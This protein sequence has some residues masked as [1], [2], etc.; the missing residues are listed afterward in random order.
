MISK[1]IHQIWFQGEDKIPEKLNNY[2]NECKKI[3]K[4]YQYYIWDDDMI[5]RL[6][7]DN[8]PDYYKTY[9]AFPLMIQKIDFA[10]YV[11]LYHYGGVYVDMDVRCLKNAT[12]LIKKFTGNDMIVSN[13]SSG[14]P[15]KWCNIITKL[16]FDFVVEMDYVNNGI[17]LV[18]KNH[19]FLLY[20][21]DE[22]SKRLP[23]YSFNIL[24]R[25]P[26]VWVSTGPGIVT[27]CIMD[28]KKK[29]PL[30]LKIIDAKYLEPCDGNIPSSASSATTADLNDIKTPCDLSDSYFIHIHEKSW[31]GV[32]NI[33]V[34]LH[35]LYNMIKEFILNAH[36]M[37]IIVI[38]V[39]IGVIYLYNKPKMKMRSFR[40]IKKV[41]TKK[42]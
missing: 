40:W 12:T 8:Y 34:Y 25:D 28:Y 11:I 19:H 21:C 9:N 39:L 38:I 13:S 4:D 23:N 31:M 5:R 35:K 27:K 6:L 30:N 18:K 14:I 29:H 37:R 1:I 2:K 7:K 36:M 15:Y 42:K 17:M 16:L 10:K 41:I 20:L 32:A 24:T 3:N 22:I 33:Y 26:Y